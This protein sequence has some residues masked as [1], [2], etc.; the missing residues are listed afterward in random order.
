MSFFDFDCLLLSQCHSTAFQL[1]PEAVDESWT[2]RLLSARG[3]A[4]D[5]PVSN[6]RRSLPG[7]SLRQGF[8]LLGSVPFF[9]LCSAHLPRKSPRYRSLSSCPATQA[10]SHGLPEPPLAQY[11][12]PRQR[13]SRLE[14]LRRFR[15]DPDGYRPRSLPRRTVRRGVV[16]DRVCLGLHDHRFMPSA[17]SLGKIPPP[18][19]RRETAHA[20]GSAGQHSSQCLCDRRPSSRRQLSGPIASRSRS[21]L[22]TRSRVPG[23]WPSL[24][25]PTR[26]RFL[27]HARQRE[28]TV[29]AAPVASGAP[30]HRTAVGS[31]HSTHRPQD[32]TPVSRPAAPHSLLR[33]RK[34]T[35]VGFSH[36]QFPAPRTHHCRPVSRSLARGVVFSLD[37]TASSYQVFLRYLGKRG[38]DASLGCDYHLCPHGQRQKTGPAGPESLQNPADSEHHPFRENPA[39]IRFFSRCRQPRGRRSVYAIETVRLMMG[40]HCPLILKRGTE[41]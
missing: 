28:H 32:L 36:Q 29:L 22:L 2:N 12:S 40:Q 37:Q 39:L 6:L 26:V 19:E 13:A 33:R 25:T 4:P 7:Q 1:V 9:G 18:Q 34:G 17:F 35:A 15:A 23:L 14:N 21:V 38:Q 11:L 30:L 5:L 27:H 31:N 3:L 8:F 41:F 10:L 20:A 16:R 24:P